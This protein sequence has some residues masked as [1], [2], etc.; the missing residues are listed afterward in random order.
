MVV[1]LVGDASRSSAGAAGCRRRAPTAPPAR[2]RGSPDRRR[3]ARRSG[4][5]EEV[6]SRGR[7][8]DAA[9]TAASM[10]GA[11]RVA[12]GGRSFV[13]S[14]ARAPSDAKVATRRLGGAGSRTP[15]RGHE[16]V[17]A[18]ATQCTRRRAADRIARAP[19][20][21]AGARRAR[22]AQA[23]ARDRQPVR[24]HG[25]RPPAQP[26]R[27]RAARAA[28]TSTPSTP[29][30]RG[31]ATELCREAAAEG[32]DVVVAFGGDGTVNEAANGLA[33]SDTPLTCL[34]GGSTNVFADARHPRRHRRRHRAPAGAGRR[35]ARRG[36]VDLGRVNGRSFTFSAG[37]RAR[38]RV[39]E[40]RRR[41]P[42]PE[43]ALAASGTSLGRGR[44]RSVASYL[45]RPPRLT[46]RRA[47]RAVRG[48]TALVQNGDRLHVLRRAARSASAASA[49]STPGRSRAVVLQRARPLDLP[50]IGARLLAD[51]AHDVADHRHVAASPASTSSRARRRT[52]ASPSRSTAT[53]SAPPRRPFGIVPGGLR[54]VA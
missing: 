33:G 4:G 2:R 52:G 49:S 44:A 26:R 51:R 27:L 7:R 35:L 41:A 13:H 45:V 53:T 30:R 34:P 23:H 22:R 42:A 11:P 15:G 31:H 9:P 48:V 50:T 29:R 39:V 36:S 10:F 54:V 47:G 25:L 17:T 8:R 6:P 37:A 12:G 16:A 18:S 38:R 5:Q 43:G 21:R 46:S 14:I 32:Y 3:G 1:V 24:D 20:R 28:T 19:R 40:P